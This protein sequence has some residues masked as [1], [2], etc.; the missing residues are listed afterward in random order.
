MAVSDLIK[1]PEGCRIAKFIKR[2]KRF[3]V[4]A[5]L[6]GEV[7]G[8]HTNNTGS[9]LGLLKEGCDIYISPAQNPARKLKWTLEMTGNTGTW[10]GV[11][12]STPNIIIE[13]AFHAGVLPELKGYTTIRREAKIGNS[14]LDAYFTDDTGKL[15]DLWVECKNVTLVEDGVACFPDAQTERGRK[16]LRELMSIAADGARVAMFFF[17]QRSDGACFGPADFIDPEYAE[18]LYEAMDAGVEVW[19]YVAKLGFEGIGVSHKLNI[20]SKPKD[21]SN[22][23]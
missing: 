7:V 3:T 22:F 4:E 14:R 21:D 5:L 9:M 2:Y 23:D 15:R 19:P 6:D 12:T 11:N 18:L 1:F 13:K 8:V 16:H 20:V 17:I 10:V